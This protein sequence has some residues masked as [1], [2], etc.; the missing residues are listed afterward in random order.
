MG[1]PCAVSGAMIMCSFGLAPSTL[2]VVAPRPIVEGRPVATIT[3]VAP[4]A[5]IA[6]FGMCQS[7]ANPVVAPYWSPDRPACAC[8]AVPF[9]LPCQAPSARWPAEMARDDETTREARH[10]D[11]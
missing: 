2:T 3:D 6:P 1:K 4:G 9:H 5:N 10:S 11:S 8:T 7:L